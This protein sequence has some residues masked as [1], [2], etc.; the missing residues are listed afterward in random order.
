MQLN[1]TYDSTSS[2]GLQTRSDKISK[3][4]Y[5]VGK[6]QRQTKAG[7]FQSH[8]EYKPAPVRIDPPKF[9]WFVNLNYRGLHIY[10]HFT[11]A[12]VDQYFT[13]SKYF[14]RFKGTPDPPYY[15]PKAFLIIVIGSI[16]VSYATYEGLIETIPK[17]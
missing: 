17:S 16:G 5:S 8:M 1:Q 13:L 10:N 12:W 3:P 7:I 9:W 11:I 2:V 4:I 14:S 15:L 6:Q